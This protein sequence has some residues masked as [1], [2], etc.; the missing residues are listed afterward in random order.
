LL[1]TTYLGV[2]AYCA[3]IIRKVF[4]PSEK[5]ESNDFYK[6]LSPERKNQVKINLLNCLQTISNNSI[7]KK[8][9]Y[10]T[11]SFFTA[12]MDN[13]E[14]WGELLK[15]II[16]LNNLQLN[17]SNFANIKLGLHLLSIV[18]AVAYDQLKEGVE[19]F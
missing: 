12:M 5:E 8:I 4:V 13:E 9:A 14:K 15:Y 11:I 7:R 1:K 3:I 16:S 2:Q 6:A 17:E 18:Y 19:M 10:A